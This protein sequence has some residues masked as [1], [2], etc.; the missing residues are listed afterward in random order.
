MILADTSAWVEFL[1]ATGSA[2]HHELVRLIDQEAEVRTTDVVVMEV[3]AGGR[4]DVEVTK[5]RRLLGR[6]ELV[7]IQGLAD[8]EAAATLYRTCRRAGETVRSLNDCLIASVAIR[9]GMSVLHHDRDYPAL[10]RHAGLLL[11]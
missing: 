7:P 4:D 10:A 2:A 5:L 11:A 1:R 9:T 3:L 6:F 8:Y